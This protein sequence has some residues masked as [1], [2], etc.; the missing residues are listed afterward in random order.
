ME[1][2]P[3]KTISKTRLL[4]WHLQEFGPGVL[5]SFAIHG[6]QRLPPNYEPGV[7]TISFTQM[8]RVPPQ[9]GPGVL[10]NPFLIWWVYILHGER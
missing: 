10:T 4:E 9:H 3:L 1:R 6:T 2:S 8:S 7:L 5:V